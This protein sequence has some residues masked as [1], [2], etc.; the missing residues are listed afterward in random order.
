[1]FTE[2]LTHPLSTE[3]S[4]YCSEGPEISLAVCPL[5]GQHSFSSLSESKR[6]QV[7]QIVQGEETCILKRQLPELNQAR[8]TMIG[9]RVRVKDRWCYGGHPHKTCRDKGPS[10]HIHGTLQASSW[11]IAFSSPLSHCKNRTLR[12]TNLLGMFKI[13]GFFLLLLFFC[14]SLTQRSQSK[15]A[16]LNFF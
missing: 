7:F 1:M 12:A 10:S 3:L 16:M 13:I 15:G 4:G 5:V 2:T 14:K 9:P 11:V 8:L 6:I